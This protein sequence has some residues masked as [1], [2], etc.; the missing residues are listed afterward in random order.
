VVLLAKQKGIIPSAK[1]V[2]DRM[3]TNGEGIQEEQYQKLL[4]TAGE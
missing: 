4:Q 2:L 3:I 1:T